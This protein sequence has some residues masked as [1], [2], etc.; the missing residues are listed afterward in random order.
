[1]DICILENSSF[2]S[3]CLEVSLKKIIDKHQLNNIQIQKYTNSK[4]ILMNIE[5]HKYHH[6]YFLDIEMNATDAN[7][8][9]LNHFIRKSVPL[10]VIVIISHHTDYMP[11]FFEHLLAS[12]HY[13][14][15]DC[16]QSQFDRRIEKILLNCL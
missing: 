16:D 9:E 10:A 15:K 13:I 2:H 8:I 7:L 3:N 4:E 12:N 5:H 1:M 14:E 11:L 6:I